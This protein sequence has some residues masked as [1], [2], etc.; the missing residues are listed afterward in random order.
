MPKARKTN[1][2]PAENEPRR[3][4]RE[5][6]LSDLKLALFRLERSGRKVS[7]K[8]V[9]DEAKVSPSLLNNR[10]PDFAEQVRAIMGKAIRQQRD[11]KA[12]QLLKARQTNRE[13]RALVDTQS[14]EITRL[15]SVNEALRSENTLLRAIAD[16]KVARGSFLRK[17]SQE[18]LS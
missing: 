11:D 15:A 17:N 6:T 14:T 7:L 13:L 3:R 12:D 5:R 16:G 10:Y 2:E 4:N 18:E 1:P 9:A 8:A